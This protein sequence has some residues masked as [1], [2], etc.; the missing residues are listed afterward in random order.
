MGNSLGQAVLASP[1]TSFLRED[2]AM[3]LALGPQSTLAQA[4]KAKS[5]P[6][7]LRGRQDPGLTPG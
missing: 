5:T 3:P 1:H 6:G 7:F 4:R 2:Q